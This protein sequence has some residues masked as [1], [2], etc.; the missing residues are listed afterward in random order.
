MCACL[1]ARVYVCVCV[2]GVCVLCMEC[3]FI[4]LRHMEKFRL[5]SL[6]FYS[7]DGDYMFHIKFFHVNAIFSFFSSKNI[8]HGRIVMYTC[9]VR[10]EAP[11]KKYG[12]KVSLNGA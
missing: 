10:L 4:E 5:P 7:V 1:L 8:V 9:T 11:S 2:C 3:M 12:E 6:L